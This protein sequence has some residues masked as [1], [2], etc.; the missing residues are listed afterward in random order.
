M[1]TQRNDDEWKDKLRA[2]GFTVFEGLKIR[3]TQGTDGHRLTI[4]IDDK[5]IVNA[6]PAITSFL[7]TRLGV[8]LIEVN[9]SEELIPVRPKADIAIEDPEGPRAVTS[10][11]ALCRDETFRGWV[12]RQTLGDFELQSDGEPLTEAEAANWLKAALYIDSRS[13]LRSDPAARRRFYA[14]R[15][16][17][18]A[19]RQQGKI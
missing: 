14:I 12:A 8:A 6:L 10:A 1:P 15:E 5:D 7:G 17:F 19:D 13:E 9:S 2:A 11:G 4:L 16:R 18:I 3:F